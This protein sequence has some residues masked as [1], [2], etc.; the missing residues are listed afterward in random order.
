MAG[1]GKQDSRYKLP[2]VPVDE[3]LEQN[4]K[5]KR[6]SVSRSGMS[7][8][9]H[10]NPHR[11]SAKASGRHRKLAPENYKEAHQTMTRFVDGIFDLLQM[12]A[13]EINKAT[14][15]SELEL[16][17]FRPEPEKDR[18]PQPVW[19]SELVKPASVVGRLS[20]RFWSLVLKGSATEIQAFILPVEKL[21]GFSTSSAGFTPYVTARSEM[22]PNGI[23]WKIDNVNIRREHIPILARHLMET[24]MKCA[25]R[26]PFEPNSFSLGGIGITAHD[27]PEEDH[28]ALEREAFYEDMKRAAGDSQP[29]LVR[30]SQDI[31][32]FKHNESLSLSPSQELGSMPESLPRS[33]PGSIPVSIP[34]SIPGSMPG[35]TP[36]TIIDARVEA[37][38]PT[39]T[40]VTAQRQR[41][42]AQMTEND[43]A[44]PVVSQRQAA[45]N[46]AVTLPSALQDLLSALELELEAVSQAGA[47]AF[48][49]REFSRAQAILEFTNRLNEFKQSAKQLYDDYQGEG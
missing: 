5:E 22:S 9:T 24:V 1:S 23:L 41:E 8:M 38:I 39:F 49:K 10:A 37:S 21:L 32:S 16:T 12:A 29:E 47:E 14:H 40:N 19:T 17:W 30:T 45:G 43:M 2:P 11:P 6:G 36:G 4:I 48:N 20:T 46:K 28:R 33:S 27:P 7:G 42:P 35:P 25:R 34:G 44:S 26:Q 31:N 15:G 3:R 13:Y 18:E